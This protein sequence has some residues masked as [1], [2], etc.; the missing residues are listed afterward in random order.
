MKEEI[1]Q[2]KRHSGDKQN[3]CWGDKGRCPCYWKVVNDRC[4]DNQSQEVVLSTSPISHDYSS[5]HSAQGQLHLDHA[6]VNHN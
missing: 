1:D 2:T 5:N 3:K 6:Y 4:G